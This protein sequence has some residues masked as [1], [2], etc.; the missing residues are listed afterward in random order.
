MATGAAV[1]IVGGGRSRKRNYSLAHF[2]ITDE[3]PIAFVHGQSRSTYGESP[4]RSAAELRA[5]GL[6]YSRSIIGFRSA[7][8]RLANASLIYIG[9]G[10]T[11]RL[12]EAL[13]DPGDRGDGNGV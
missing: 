8:C 7:N 9:E 5:A 10:S 2:A 13:E 12:I 11:T 1:G 6:R 3:S 4:C